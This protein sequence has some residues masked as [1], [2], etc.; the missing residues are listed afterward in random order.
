MK[1]KSRYIEPFFDMPKTRDE[2]NAKRNNMAQGNYPLSMTDCEVVGISGL[3]G[4]ECCVY[5]DAE[6]HDPEEFIEQKLKYMTLW[7]IKNH[8]D[9]YPEKKP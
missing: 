8:Y 4:L 1:Q 5:Q 7:D 6:C 9:M 2:V 3:C